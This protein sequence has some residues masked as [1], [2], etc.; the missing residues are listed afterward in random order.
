MSSYSGSSRRSRRTVAKTYNYMMTLKDET[1][2]K[3]MRPITSRTKTKRVAMVAI[4][5][6]Q[7]S[8]TAQ[9]GPGGW[10]P[11]YNP[12]DWCH[13]ELI[14]D[15][16]KMAT[17]GLQKPHRSD[18]DSEDPDRNTVS[19]TFYCT[20]PP[21]KRTFIFDIRHDC[22]SNEH[23]THVPDDS[24]V[25]KII[26]NFRKAR[27]RYADRGRNHHDRF[28][29]GKRRRQDIGPQ[30]AKKI[31]MDMETKER[32]SVCRTRLGPSQDHGDS[33]FFT[34]GSTPYQ[35]MEWDDPICIASVLYDS[36][37][38]LRNKGWL[39][40][41]ENKKDRK[42]FPNEDWAKVEQNLKEMTNI[43]CCDLTGEDDPSN[44]EVWTTTTK[45]KYEAMKGDCRG[46]SE[47]RYSSRT[48][49]S[50]VIDLS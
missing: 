37:E 4:P 11:E 16:E 50:D 12:Y 23:F 19:H 41:L 13:L 24:K 49:A 40:P 21:Q 30:V 38:N 2:G 8:V 10:D 31:R 32:T 17:Y 7:F 42:Y 9:V 28:R 45:A 5:G 22:D 34:G 43:D 33:G 35:V 39:R 25:G 1:T 18:L 29:P 46:D 27:K 3:V 14:I 44:D 36:A 48:G 47:S 15:G 26:V 6:H 20:K